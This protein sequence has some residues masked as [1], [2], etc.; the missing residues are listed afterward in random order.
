AYLLDLL[1]RK[2]KMNVRL[3]SAV[4]APPFWDELQRMDPEVRE[5]FNLCIV[6]D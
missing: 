1:V 5:A 6:S 3:A 2:H 4:F